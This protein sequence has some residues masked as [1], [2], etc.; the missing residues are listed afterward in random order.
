MPEID[1]YSVS[2]IPMEMMFGSTVL[3]LGTG[4][5]FASSGSFFVV[6]NW[7]NFSGKNPSTGVH[8]SLTAAEPDRI[9]VW[10][11]TRGQLGSKFSVEIPIKDNNGQPLW[12]VH[13]VHRELIDVAALPVNPHAN[14]DPY[15]I[16]QMSSVELAAGIGSDVF[17]LGYPFG[18]GPGG[19][20]VW[21]R[22]SIASEPELVGL[23]NQHFILVDTAS[24]PGMSGSPVIVR[25]RGA[26]PMADGSVAVMGT[27]TRVVGVYSGRLSTN[28]PLDAQLGMVWPIRLVDEIINGAS[29]DVGMMS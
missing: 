28:D 3:S 21:K 12:F 24:R 13:P 10:W 9:R 14:A 11:N 18:I 1:Q 15:P 20:P 25:S 29:R 19:L 7:H 6:S 27:A 17:I 26:S 5:V 16:N 2:T 22:G 8:L 4:F 23:N